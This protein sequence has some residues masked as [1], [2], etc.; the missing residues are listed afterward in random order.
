MLTLFALMLQTATLD[1]DTAKAAITCA[2][3]FTVTDADTKSAMQLTSQFT[4][5]TMQAAKAKPEGSFFEQ[6]NKL[7]AQASAGP[8]MTAEQAKPFVPLCDRRFPLAR[9]SAPAKLPSDSFRRD[10]L[11][12]GVLSV[13]QGA[14][15]EIAKSG[16]DGGL[17]KIK[18]GLKPLT[19][20]LTDDELKRRGLG[21]DGAFLKALGDEM[22]GALSSGNPITLSAAC[23]VSLS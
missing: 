21:S 13:M 22:L 2:K 10:V 8:A 12:F 14:A 1:A 7:S 17:T 3:T 23:G 15:E 20:K 5:L 16:V 19:D 6:L 18:A 4:H 9:G 11:C